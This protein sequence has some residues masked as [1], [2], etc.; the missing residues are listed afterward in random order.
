MKLG[1]LALLTVA[2]SVAAGCAQDQGDGNTG[3]GPLGPGQVATVNGTPIQESLFRLYTL[4]G[5]QK[6]ADDL[7]DEE[8]E[9]IVG[10]LVQLRVLA[11]AAQESGILNERTI[12][13]EIEL[14]RLQLIAR[15]VATRFLEENPA[16]EAEV[17]A[18][19]EENL[20]Q[21]TS[22]QYKA[23]HILLETEADASSVIA[24]VKVMALP[25]VPEGA[26]YHL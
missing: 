25:A 13:A 12:A 21:L 24:W 8:R 15:T 3:P 5:L 11:D 6:S 22:T 9:R 14:Q 7:T 20:S 16:S 2:L 23:R 19:Y 10:E 17:R 4:N 1:S 26:V 18:V